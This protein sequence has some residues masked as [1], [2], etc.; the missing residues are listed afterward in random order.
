LLCAAME[1]PQNGPSATDDRQLPQPPR[2]NSITD[3]M[4]EVLQA[5][6]AVAR[7][8][9]AQPQS[10]AS[11]G[12]PDEPLHLLAVPLKMDDR[13]LGVAGLARKTAPYDPAAVRKLEP[14]LLTCASL[15]E[16][17]RTARRRQEA[18]ARIRELNADLEKRV[19]ER[20]AD[21]RAMNEELAEFAYV[22]THDLK[23]PLRGINQLAEWLTQD[24]AFGLDESGL[25]LLA[26]LRRRVLHLQR[27]VDGLLACARV[28]RSPEPETSVSVAQLLHDVIGVLAP[29]PQVVI[30]IPHSLPTIQG[31]PERLHQIFQNLLDNAVKYLDKPEGLIRVQATRQPGAWEFR[32]IDNGPGIPARYREKVFQIFQRLD[33]RGD[34]P[35]T[36]LGLTLVRRIIEAR[37]GRAWIESAEGRG[38]AVCFTWTDRARRRSPE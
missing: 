36:G 10:P 7:T 15:F 31:N 20:T 5:Q 22:V 3:L 25:K 38:T 8:T 27:L 29:P 18:E 35:G 16:A 30:D 28:G 33:T 17:I 2:S 32:V 1:I 19:E 21:L 4:E 6:T 13:M 14:L 26:L 24:H 23:A 12:T 11:A 9:Q 37:G 34:I